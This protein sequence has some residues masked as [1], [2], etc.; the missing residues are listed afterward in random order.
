MS[1]ATGGWGA[2]L[3]LRCTYALERHGKSLRNSF[4]RQWTKFANSGGVFTRM[5][6][7]IEGQE[8]SAYSM[9]FY[10]K[11]M[12]WRVLNVTD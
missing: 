2:A 6:F 7:K 4:E 11:D 5:D 10:S 3:L 12:V 1:V 8:K 9:R